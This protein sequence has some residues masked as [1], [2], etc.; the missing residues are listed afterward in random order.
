MK[1][2]NL[3]TFLLFFVGSSFSQVKPLHFDPAAEILHWNQEGVLLVRLKTQE[4][5]IKSLQRQGAALE[6]KELEYERRQYHRFLR[7]AFRDHYD[8]TK[9]YFFFNRDAHRVLAGDYQ[10]A[11]FDVNGHRFSSPLMPNK[12]VYVLDSYFPN[13]PH[14]N[15]HRNEKEGFV[16]KKVMN[17]GIAQRISTQMPYVFDAPTHIRNKQHI[18]RLNKRVLEFNGVLWKQLAILKEQELGQ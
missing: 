5:R 3:F 8:F 12:S 6:A 2:I 10:N 7:E 14:F 1:P 9:V 16:V 13:H 11:L 17:N 4:N 18:D 15:H